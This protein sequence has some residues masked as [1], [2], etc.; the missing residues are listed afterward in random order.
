MSGA[1]D[2]V[3]SIANC[4]VCQRSGLPILPLRYAVTRTDGD[5]QSGHP[6]GPEVSGPLLDESLTATPLPEGQRYTL[7]LL[8]AGFLYVFNET[9][10]RWLGHV[11]TDK[12]YLIEYVDIPHDEVLAIDPN[13][14]QPIDGRLQ[15]PAE[16]QE[17]ACA[18]NPAHAYPGRCVMIPDA[19]E[20]DSIY[21]SF[22][23]VAW[24]KRVWKEHATN[25]N[26]RRDNM[27]RLSLAEW[28]GGSAPYAESLEKLG[29]YL[30][31]A[32]RI[33]TPPTRPGA[34][35]TWNPGA[36]GSWREDNHQGKA[37]DF[38]P[39]PFHGMKEQVEGLQRWADEQAEPLEMMSML[40]AL[41]DPV[42][43]TADLAGLM[44]VRLKEFMNS[45]GRRWPLATAAT[46]NALEP[47]IRE[48]AQFQY[49]DKRVDSGPLHRP[50]FAGP[51]QPS[52][53]EQQRIHAYHDRLE[54]SR[55]AGTDFYK[56]ERD[57][58]RKEVAER[59]TPEELQREADDA[60]DRYRSRLRDGQPE[61]WKQ[62]QFKPEQERFDQNVM[63]PLAHAHRAWL[64]GTSIQ[65]QFEAHFDDEDAE[66]G[67]AFTD[68]VVLCIQDTQ[69]YGPAFEKYV[70]WLTAPNITDDN[71][72][73][74][75][76]LLNLKVVRDAVNTQ[77]APELKTDQVATLSWTG[78]V[79]SYQS[80][81]ER[82]PDTQ[83]APG[84][85]LGAVMAPMLSAL[86]EQTVRPAL[87]ALGVISGRKVTHTRVS[88]HVSDAIDGLIEEMQRVNP[89]LQG[90]D[91][92]LL[93]EKLRIETRG[94][95]RHMQSLGKGNFDISMVFDTLSIEEIDTSSDG[96]TVANQVGDTVMDYNQW[97]QTQ[98][99]VW[100]SI[101]DRNTQLGIVSLV[102]GYWA[103][104]A[105]S[106]AMDE[107]TT[108]ERTETQ[109]RFGALVAGAA[110]SVADTGHAILE[111]SSRVGGRLAQKAGKVWQGVLRI[112]G[113][114]L[115]F[116]AAV[117][118][119]FWDLHNAYD[120]ALK[121]SVLLASLYLGSAVFGAGAFIALTFLS[122]TGVGIALAAAAV[123]VNIFIALMSN[124]ALQD[125]MEKCYFGVKDSDERFS[126]FTSETDAFEALSNK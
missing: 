116:A 44:A 120:K 122:A 19:N 100:G 88:G 117:V 35:G 119:A 103:I 40:V 69:Q 126:D 4:R 57:K 91:Q 124:N 32:N 76:F 75:G 41:E 37:F 59:I 43:I 58:A 107:A 125:W 61:F 114:L 102:L 49:I 23:D 104:C 1:S 83:A 68:T 95:Y 38:S 31:E 8:R 89:A 47:A 10:G 56:N 27:R 105:Q 64:T 109:W 17:F 115:G 106:K 74:R 25:A 96:R 99:S 45:D 111:R 53:E 30:S 11:V 73:L 93:K 82:Y 72:L 118:M 84:R 108:N 60:W 86:D 20:A 42:G 48:Q 39:F 78:L 46:L 14:P 90:A 65:K 2:D 6:A 33:W 22:S 12:G 36:S 13:S 52:W 79:S 26:Q 77:A 63:L 123:V 110:G 28:R 113:R 18:A 71:W 15:P 50:I 7:R 92:T 55:E 98:G 3:Q 112:G 16:E 9:R 97:R 87:I 29:D 80:A 66:S 5:D 21:L 85:L 34:S 24:T 121:G 54:A 67:Q 94:S 81:T 70:E 101:G 62:T 51:G